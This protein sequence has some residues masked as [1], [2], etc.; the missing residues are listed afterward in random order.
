MIPGCP[1]TNLNYVLYFYV[2]RDKLFIY[3]FI[4]MFLLLYFDVGFL[5]KFLIFSPHRGART[6]TK[7]RQVGL[8]EDPR[9]LQQVLHAHPPRLWH[10]QSAA[11]GLPRHHQGVEAFFFFFALKLCML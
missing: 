4:Y 8:G 9:L 5:T 2:T 7:R 10:E 6:F 11:A 1:S 3:N